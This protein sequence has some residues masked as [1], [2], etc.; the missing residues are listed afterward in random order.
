MERLPEWVCAVAPD[1][2]GF[3]GSEPWDD[4]GIRRYHGFISALLESEGAR[5]PVFVGHDLGGLYALTYALANPDG[6]R[7]L[8]MLNTTI[9]PDA[10]VVL[11]LLPLLLP[12]LV[13]AYAWLAGRKRYRPVVERS[14]RAMYPPRQVARR[15]LR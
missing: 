8:V 10:S 2:P 1:L 3:G 14:L 13:E 6:L 15:W 4:P 11:G 9:Y 5:E 12:G 7:A